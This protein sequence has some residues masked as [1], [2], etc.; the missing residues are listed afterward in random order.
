[1]ITKRKTKNLSTSKRASISLASRFFLQGFGIITAPLFTRLLTVDEYG[2]LSIYNS[3]LAIFCIFM[4]LQTS[5]SMNVARVHYSEEEFPKYVS[6]I[7]SLS[8]LCGLLIASVLLLFLNQVS[9]LVELPVIM[10]IIMIVHSFFKY[11]TNFLSTWA[12]ITKRAYL[13]VAISVTFLVLSVGISILLIN[14]METDKQLGRIFGTIIPTVFLGILVLIYFFTTGKTFINKKYWVYCLPI[15]IPMV[16]HG[17]SGLLLS[18]ADKIIIGRLVDVGSVAVYNV[19]YRV[20]AIITI[21]IVAMRSNWIPDAMEMIKNK[22][23][24]KLVDQSTHFTKNVLSVGIMVIAICPEVIKVLFSQ[25]Y[26]GGIEVIPIVVSGYIIMFMYTFASLFETYHRKNIMYAIATISAA[27]VNIILNIILVPIYGIM[28]AAFTTLIS[29]IVMFAIHQT[30]TKL[31]FKEFPYK[32]AFF[33]K[34]FVIM[35]IA[36]ASFYF[37]QDFWYI[38]YPIAIIIGISLLLRVVRRRSYY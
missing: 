3:Y 6:S 22:D 16:F 20:S 19:S 1:M 28:G 8:I 38:R 5:A 11:F 13:Q 18:H 36:V 24:G 32:N 21:L 26:W 14:N 7:L 35:A 37:I 9:I 10:I 33:A 25:E 15:A 29:Y 17:I 2:L 4:G 34:A 27:V 23:Y 30:F 12:I 31:Q